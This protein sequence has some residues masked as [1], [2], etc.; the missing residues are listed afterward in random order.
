L[1]KTVLRELYL[2]HNLPLAALGV[3]ILWVG[4][5]GF[6]PGSQLAITGTG[7][8]DAVMLIA[9]NTTLAAA[10]GGFFAMLAVWVLHKKPELSM[11]LNGNSCRSCGYYRKL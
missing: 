5:Y 11:A 3:F 1:Q 4:W 2:G 10:A 9:T 8:T 6:N 7:N